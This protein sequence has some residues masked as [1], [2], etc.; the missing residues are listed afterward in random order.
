MTFM[1][2]GVAFIGTQTS[3][4]I[5]HFCGI[6]IFSTALKAKCLSNHDEFNLIFLLQNGSQDSIVKTLNERIQH[7]EAENKTVGGR[8]NT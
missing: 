4:E 6:L 3:S 7:L 5:G 1:E 2:C 8:D